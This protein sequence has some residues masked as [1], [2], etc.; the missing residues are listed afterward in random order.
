MNPNPDLRTTY[1]WRLSAHAAHQARAR[2]VSVREILEVIADPWIRH[3]A[4]NEGIGRYMYKRGNLAVVGV[5]AERTVV[6]VLWNKAGEW[7]SE[8]F[9]TRDAA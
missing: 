2:G 5:P 4:F 9:R 6:T 1:G 7:T 8:E 3:T